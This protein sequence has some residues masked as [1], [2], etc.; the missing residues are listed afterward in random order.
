MAGPRLVDA[1]QHFW[2]LERG[3]YAWLTPDLAPIYR[4]FGPGDLAPLLAQTGIRETVLVQAA[5]TVAETQFLLDVASTTP[6]VAGVVGWAPLDA[7]DAADI[8]A[9]LAQH[10]ALKGLRPMLQ[11]IHDP[12]WML[13]APV[14]QGLRTV[15][16]FGLAFDALV[17]PAH[18]RNLRRLL[19]NHPGLRVVVDHGAKPEIAA[20]RFGPWAADI[21]GLA[22]ETRAWVK[23]SGLVTE[24]GP[25]WSV[26]RLRPYVEHLL[27]YFGPHRLIFGSDWPV[28]TLRAGY[29]EWL[30]A[31]ETL[32]AGL[33]GEARARIMGL[34]AVEVYRL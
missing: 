16:A 1:H 20:G 29:A 2:R 15:E 14:G 24:A 10:P 22:E 5:P 3:D 21:R 18:L 33:E 19:A 13:R 32:L 26:E 17:R 9:T 4:D 7:P 25:D 8:V 30:A 27:E 28:V 11:D 12:D 6:F 31:A 34:N 23:L